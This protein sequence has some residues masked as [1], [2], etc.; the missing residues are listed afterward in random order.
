MF[1]TFDD[2]S[3]RSML[4]NFEK[5]YKMAQY[6]SADSEYPKIIFWAPIPLLAMQHK[7]K[8]VLYH[9]YYYIEQFGANDASKIDFN[10]VTKYTMFHFYQDFLDT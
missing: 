5:S 3:K 4:Q 7:L 9:I 6:S 1:A 8:K 2:F 10:T